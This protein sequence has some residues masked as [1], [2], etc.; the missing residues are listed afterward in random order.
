MRVSPIPLH[1]SVVPSTLLYV[2]ERIR[3]HVPSRRVILKPTPVDVVDTFRTI[4]VRRWTLLIV[5]RRRRGSREERDPSQIPSRWE[6][7]NR[8]VVVCIAFGFGTHGIVPKDGFRSSLVVVG[9]F[10]H[11][12]DGLHVRFDEAKKTKTFLSDPSCERSTLANIRSVSPGIAP[13]GGN[14]IG[15]EVPSSRLDPGGSVRSFPF[16]RETNVRS[17]GK[18][19]RF[20]SRNAWGFRGERGIGFDACTP[21][22][23]KK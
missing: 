12:L 19:I 21:R 13:G 6:R 3:I 2:D 16:E 1:A 4:L 9:C 14:P 22:P 15:R 5:R 18:K 17:K 23:K 20:R 11:V 8:W 7:T 10:G